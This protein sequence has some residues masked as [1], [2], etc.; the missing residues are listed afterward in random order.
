LLDSDLFHK[1][2]R[3]PIK[4][5]ALTTEKALQGIRVLDVTHAWAGPLVGM[6]LADMGAEVIHVE[7][8]GV[9]DLQRAA[10]V[11]GPP[12]EGENLVFL[13]FN[14]NKKSITLDLKAQKGNEIFKKL[15]KKSDIV[16]QNFSPG[17]MEKLGL[18][19]DA[20]S[21]INA[22]IIMVSVS[23][24][25]Q[26]GP[27]RNQ[28]AYDLTAQAMSGLMSVTGF[29]DNPPLRC[30]GVVA[31][32]LGGLY[33]FCGVMT[34]LYWREKSGRG[35]HVD[36][37]LMDGASFMVSDR[38]V[39]YAALREPELIARLGNRYPFM[40]LTLCYPTRD[41]HFTFRFPTEQAPFKI[42]KLIGREDLL[43]ESE[44]EQPSG[45]METVTLLKKID[46]PLREFLA[47]KTNKEAMQILEEID[48]ACSPVLSIEKLLEDP[49]FKARE[50][51][52]EVEHPRIGRI[53]IPGVVPKLSETPGKV[54]TPGPSL[55]QHNEEI[56][57][58]LLGYTQEEV[59][60]LKEE[61]II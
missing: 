27:Y 16:V 36:I 12:L 25:G 44:I 32:Q 50:M 10:E 6:Y 9:G 24:F 21:K 8:T 51:L 55:G 35:Q 43:A 13:L 37:S 34:A 60:I 57:S 29:P 58:N 22:G 53:K 28:H 39:R 7:K 52:V 45:Y 20:L 54:E 59:A 17:T 41:G 31:D 30:G 61:K 47:E 56:Y 4:E 5:I 42:A 46:A 11:H 15:V 48:V 14:R 1:P 38:I 40:P 33:G 2:E 23:G 3:L 26:N 19:Y 49:Q 18:G